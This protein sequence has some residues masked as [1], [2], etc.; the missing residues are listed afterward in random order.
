MDLLLPVVKSFWALKGGY[1][2]TACQ[3][4]EIG[5]ES[6]FANGGRSAYETYRKKD[7]GHVCGPEDLVCVHG[8]VSY[9]VGYLHSE[10]YLSEKYQSLGDRKVEVIRSKWLTTGEMTQSHTWREYCQYALQSGGALLRDGSST[11]LNIAKV[12]HS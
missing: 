10:R 11:F 12:F 7:D 4:F 9:V 1:S 3:A 5:V 6:N 2:S 8:S